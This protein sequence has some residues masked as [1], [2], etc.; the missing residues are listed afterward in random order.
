NYATFNDE[1]VYTI[2][3]IL[4]SYEKDAITLVCNANIENIVN[5]KFDNF[6]KKFTVNNTS[7]CW[8]QNENTIIDFLKEKFYYYYIRSKNLLK[9]D[10]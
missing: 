6:E 9:D 2:N 4:F 3:D 8:I 10:N 1:D 5:K 7:F